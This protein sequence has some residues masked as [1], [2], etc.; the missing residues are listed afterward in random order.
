VCIT[1]GGSLNDI[2]LADDMRLEQLLEEL[3]VHPAQPWAGGDRIRAVDR[4]W[5][6]HQCAPPA[7]EAGHG[8]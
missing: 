7:T 5:C 1:K 4:S 8:N 6:F 3:L 2:V